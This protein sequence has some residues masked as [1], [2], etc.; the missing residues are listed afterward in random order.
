LSQVEQTLFEKWA[1]PARRRARWW[2]GVTPPQLF[3]SS[4]IFMIL[5][6]TVGL[7]LIPGLYIDRGLSWTDALFTS[8]SAVCITGLIVVDTA[9]HFTFWGQL[10]L[11]VLIQLGGLGMVTFTSLIIVSLGRRLSLRQ[12]A[13]S[14]ATRPIAPD[15]N[16]THLLRDVF[17]FTF[18]VEAFVAAMLYIFWVRD[19]GW[20]G[21]I[22][23]SIF[24]AVSSF[25]NAGFSTFSDSLTGFQANA[26]VLLVVSL[27]IVI[28][29]T[30]FLTLEELYLRYKAG[31]REQIFRI[32]LHS[33]IV[34]AMTVLLMVV[35]WFGYALFEWKQGFL[36]MSWVD[37]VVNALFMS[38]SC[39]TAGL[40]TIDHATA[41]DSTNFMTI[42]L[43]AIGGSPGSTAG[44]LKTT[45]IALIGLYAW[46]R[47]RGREVTTIQ[48]RSVPTETIQ[49]AVGLFV[50]GFGIMTLAIFAM[51]ATEEGRHAHAQF[52]H[53]MFEIVS[54]FNTTGL[55]MG[56]T[57]DLSIPSKWMTTLLMF[58][59]R[60]GPLTF[61]AALA[62]RR[63][64]RA[65]E[66]RYAYEDVVIG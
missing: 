20:A 8:T 66:F 63:P 43:M 9:T 53:Y 55:S 30:G 34:L 42:I 33:R 61:A 26:G 41:T 36:H 11:L 22:W 59:G 14:M 17:V 10:Y 51:I 45:T 58:M 54:A 62:M 21:A 7:Q 15:V 38:A 56:V 1:I 47:I 29:G 24:H 50:V 16:P 5:A 49:R 35:G 3:V 13:L 65:R 60:I 28:G 12:E 46:S 2:H 23:P 32:S 64:V 4:F 25:C 40:N 6:G 19:L 18:I 57:Q 39:R 52:L 44:G 27:A 31:R 37:K 48:G